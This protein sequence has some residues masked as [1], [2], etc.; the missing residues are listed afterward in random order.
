MPSCMEYQLRL[1]SC[2]QLGSLE[3]LKKVDR[4]IKQ[5]FSNSPSASENSPAPGRERV[6]EARNSRRWEARGVVSRG[7][8]DASQEPKNGPP[9]QGYLL[10]G[11]RGPGR[12]D[13]ALSPKGKQAQLLNGHS[14]HYLRA[15]VPVTASGSHSPSVLP[16]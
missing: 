12:P 4:G 9:Q 5:V 15:G 8:I 3:A 2:L 11:W 10:L 7:E 6:L 14:S 13:K 1:S 16:S